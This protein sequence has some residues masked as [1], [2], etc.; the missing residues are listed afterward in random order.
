METIKNKLGVRTIHIYDIDQFPQF[1]TRQEVKKI[2]SQVSAEWPE[3]EI[4]N[5]SASP[6]KGLARVKVICA[7]RS[8]IIWTIFKQVED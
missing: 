1:F 2:H 4:K 7:G 6:E 5:V 8:F 3:A